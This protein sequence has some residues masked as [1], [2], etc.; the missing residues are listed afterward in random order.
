MVLIASSLAIKNYINT[1]A[2]G[3]IYFNKRKLG[4]G[5]RDLSLVATERGG[6]MSESP[7]ISLLHGG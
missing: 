1:S 2:K 4:V 6:I 7:T 3:C 5:H